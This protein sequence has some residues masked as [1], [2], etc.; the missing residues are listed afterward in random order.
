MLTDSDYLRTSCPSLCRSYT[1]KET[2][3]RIIFPSLHQRREQ[4]SDAK[5]HKSAM[6]EVA[7]SKPIEACRPTKNEMDT[8]IRL[9]VLAS[10]R[11]SH[12]SPKLE[13][14]YPACLNFPVGLPLN[15]SNVS[16]SEPTECV[17]NSS[18]SDTV[19]LRSILVNKS[20]RKYTK[21]CFGVSEHSKATNDCEEITDTSSVVSDIP[22]LD[23]SSVSTNSDTYCY[24][25]SVA[26]DK[27]SHRISTD[28]RMEGR[29]KFGHN[30][31][32]REFQR[33][34]HEKA[35]MWFTRQEMHSFKAAALQLILEYNIEMSSATLS[36]SI[37]ADTTEIAGTGTGRVVPMQSRTVKPSQKILFTHRALSPDSIDSLH[38]TERST[39]A[40]SMPLG[41][42]TDNRL[43]R[44]LSCGNLAAKQSEIRRVLVVDSHDAC[45][46]LFAKGLLRMFPCAKV[47]TA[48]S[49]E[50]ALGYSASCSTQDNVYFDMIIVE[51]RLK[52][53]PWRADSSSATATSGS[54]LLLELQSRQSRSHHA[55]LYIG[56]SA[57]VNDDAAKLKEHGADIVWSKP[58]PLMDRRLRDAI[59]AAIED[60]R[61]VG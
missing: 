49:R 29:V 54:S 31:R 30:V 34:A 60:K 43:V 44:S 58:P 59:V 25:A 38:D 41:H 1:C 28:N 12:R 18:S 40:L 5:A 16:R 47:T 14:R 37:V 4:K 50:E 21:S 24:V 7:R 9:N 52:L 56:V 39:A 15:H 32:V 26:T 46:D 2:K 3:R 45:L 36:S 57:H 17:D 53:L 33:S 20:Q 27:S 61:N 35:H 6:A 8:F 11:G 42:G 22:S 23:S 10:Q 48:R 19:K 13:K 51:E 55:A